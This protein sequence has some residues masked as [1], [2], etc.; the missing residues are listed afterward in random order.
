MK[1]AT[2]DGPVIV[3]GWAAGKKVFEEALD[4]DPESEDAFRHMCQLLAISPNWMIEV[5]FLYMQEE[6]RFLRFGTDKSP[7]VDPLKV[8]IE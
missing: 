5:E 8:T 3:R 1:E 2:E 4:R 6:E 7:M